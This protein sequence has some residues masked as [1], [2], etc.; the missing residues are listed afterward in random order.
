MTITS[1]NSTL[2]ITA[3]KDG[4]TLGV[5][6]S[7]TTT[8]DQ[9]VTAKDTLGKT[10]A[11]TFTDGGKLVITGTKDYAST[12]DLGDFTLDSNVD[13]TPVIVLQTAGSL[14]GD[15]AKG[16][17]VSTTSSSL[18]KAVL[19][20]EKAATQAEKQDLEAKLTLGSEDASLGVLLMPTL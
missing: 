2:T 3:G 16:T 14:A 10:P 18:T 20:F 6:G 15:Q 1:A 9:A 4:N 5:T 12:V 19:S 13:N 11:I 17:S 7:V 8:D